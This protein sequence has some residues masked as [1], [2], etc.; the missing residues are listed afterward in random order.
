M[1]DLW[2]FTGLMSC[3]GSVLLVETC[4]GLESHVSSSSLLATCSFTLLSPVGMSSGFV[5]SAGWSELTSCN[6]S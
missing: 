1:P 6:F 3:I 2:T 5:S 4:S